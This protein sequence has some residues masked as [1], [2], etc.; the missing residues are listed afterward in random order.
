MESHKRLKVIICLLVTTS[1]W[2]VYGAE[3]LL[4]GLHSDELISGELIIP[5]KVTKSGEFISHN[6]IHHHGQHYK[7]NRKR[8]SLDDANLEPEVHYHVDIKNETL[9]LELEPHSYFMTPHLIVERHRRDVRTRKHL[10][11]HTNCHYHGRIKD[12]PDSRVA[13]SACN[14][15]VGHIKTENNEY[16]IEPSKPHASSAHNVNGHPHVVFQRSSVKEKQS[17]QQTNDKR[18]QQQNRR[19][20]QQLQQQ[21][22]KLQ[23]NGTKRQRRSLSNCGTKEPRRRIEARLVEWQPQ[24]KVKIQGG[25][26]IR[27]LHHQQSQYKYETTTTDVKQQENQ[28]QQQQQQHSHH[29]FQSHKQSHS[30][31]NHKE[32]QRILTSDTPP[33]IAFAPQA[34]PPSHWQHQ[35]QPPYI[36]SNNDIGAHAHHHQ[37][38]KR[39]ISSPR[40]VETLIVADSTMVAFHA[41]EV[42]LYLLTIMNMV[43]ALYKD[44]SIGNA[45]EIVVVKIILLD[46]EEAH[47]DLNLTQNAQQNLDKFCSWQHKLNSGN[48]FDPHHHDVAVL[49]TRKNICGNNCM[50][51][52]LANVGGMCKPKQSCSVNEDNGIMLSHT[53]AHEL[54]HNFGM[55]HD[56]AKIGCH[57]RVGSIVHIM[58]P[59]FGADT[60][61]VCWSNCS[62]KFIT[63]FL[64]QGLGDCLDDEPTPLDEYAYPEEQPGKKYNAELQ[65]RLQYNVTDSEVCSPMFEICSTLW[66]KVNGECITN[67]RPTAPGT[68]C[69]KRKWC[70]NGKCVRIESMEKV[71]GSWGN[72]SEWSECSRSCGGGVSI[73]QRE[74]DSPR[75]ANGGTFCIGE[76]K[77]YKICNHQPCPKNEPS[78]R[79]LQCAKYNKKPYQGQFYKW[80]P[81]FDKQNPCKLY[82]N[83]EDDT[84]IANWGDV[85]LDGTPCTLGTNNMCIDGICRKVGC[86]WIVDSDEQ[87]DRCGVC[88]GEGL[89]CKTVKY[90]YND[91]LKVSEGYVEIVV[92]PAKARH[93][94]IKELGNSPHF[95]G[96][97]KSNSSQFYLNGDSLISMPGEFAIAGAESFYD[98]IDDQEII[99]IPQPI[100]HSIAIYNIVRGDEPNEGIY[101]EFTLPALNASSSKHYLWKLSEWTQCSVTCGG[102]LQ[103]REPICYENGRIT[104]DTELC[105]AFAKNPR[106]QR[107]TKKCSSLPC[108]A[109]WLT[110]PW[111]FCPVTC[112]NPDDPLPVRRRSVM[113]L[114]PHDV[115]LD[116]ERCNPSTRPNDTDYCESNLPDCS[117]REKFKNRYS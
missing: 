7:H 99:K 83:D 19:K 87:E 90:V 109:H 82:C 113:C 102:G 14:G 59:T 101:Y 18:K 25:R 16:Y 84:I 74:C 71:D 4:I 111:Q 116:D 68:M 44:P 91:T 117:I 29:F 85:V 11:M 63:H 89:E 47:I 42:E 17:A 2:L 79:A 50:T 60:L 97:A 45:I 95:L 40:H 69:G 55:F 48:E 34:K 93:I 94:I 52:G 9:H 62:R 107:L 8:R 21:R 96:V 57:P 31:N 46:E 86:D 70:Q 54:G 27:R 38:M 13:L 115:I 103:Y 39:S 33:T 51:L 10:D 37:R 110:G 105:W 22:N 112:R 77:K 72:W 26:K 41:K 30:S 88:G 114:D 15:L 80:L 64:D 5:R 56:T 23:Q 100:Q 65:C 92:L 53:I 1:T 3:Q 36:H 6:L 35:Q 61:Q 58:T 28:E 12:Q 78:F 67:M 49:I 43:S 73:Q 81:Y 20:Q 24:G 75:P 106:P 66:C 104:S 108:P 32:S 76:R 98:R